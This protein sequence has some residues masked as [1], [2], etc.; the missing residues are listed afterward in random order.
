AHKQGEKW[1][2]GPAYEQ[3]VPHIPDLFLGAEPKLDSTVPL[4]SQRLQGSVLVVEDD[5]AIR[6]MLVVHLERLGLT[7]TQARD[8]QEAIDS[9]ARQVPDLAIL[10]AMLPK[11]HGFEVI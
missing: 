2:T 1:L 10:D 9:L 8:G 6:K 3:E 7:V 11:V 4:P 5:A